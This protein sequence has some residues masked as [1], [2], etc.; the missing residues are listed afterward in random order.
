MGK[1]VREIEIHKAVGGQLS[2]NAKFIIEFFEELFEDMYIYIHENLLYIHF[3]KNINGE[4]KVLMSQN[5]K[6]DYLNCSYNSMWDFLQ[7]K[8]SYSDQETSN[9]IKYMVE[10]HLNSKVGTP[11][12]QIP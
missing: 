9:L 4:F 6:N 11:W 5:L 2:D 7:S 12:L 1:L 8:L 10:Q 3:V